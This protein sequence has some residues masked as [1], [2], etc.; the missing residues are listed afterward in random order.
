MER[1]AV[2]APVR[3]LGCGRGW[4]VVLFVDADGSGLTRRQ[5]TPPP[6]QA[7]PKLDEHARRT[8]TLEKGIAP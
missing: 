6:C 5:L 4:R 7:S 1:P 2:G 8:F 3:A